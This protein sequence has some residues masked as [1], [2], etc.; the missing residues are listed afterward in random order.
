MSKNPADLG[1]KKNL[2]LTC[3]KS[4]SGPWEEETLETPK[5]CRWQLSTV[6]PDT[7]EQ[8]WGLKEKT[9]K[10]EPPLP[11]D[12]FEPNAGRLDCPTPIP[13]PFS[14]SCCGLVPRNTPFVSFFVCLFQTG[15][16][17]RKQ[18]V[19]SQAHNFLTARKRGGGGRRRGFFCLSPDPVALFLKENA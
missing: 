17:Y 9:H 7:R 6:F 12:P 16:N 2:I 1:K 19:S 14:F 8:K 4:P 15:W 11:P 13:Q 3:P 18:S 5:S 10:V